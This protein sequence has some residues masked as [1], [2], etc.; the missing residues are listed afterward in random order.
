MKTWNE[1][2][3]GCQ[4][5]SAGLFTL[6][7]MKRLL[8]VLGLA[9]ADFFTFFFA[10]APLAPALPVNETLFLH[11]DT[12]N[13]VTQRTCLFTFVF[14]NIIIQ[15][16]VKDLP[17]IFNIAYSIWKRRKTSHTYTHTCSC[18]TDWDSPSSTIQSS[19]CLS[20][21]SFEYCSSSTSSYTLVNSSTWET[22][23]LAEGR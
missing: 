17:A 5:T 16:I 9:T 14:H 19:S 8:M 18:V 15:V 22:S 21:T 3:Q 23:T 20:R 11:Q 6:L 7:F 2:E 4:H 1:S 13:S 12:S 10:S